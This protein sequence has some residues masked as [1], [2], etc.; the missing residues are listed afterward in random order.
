[1]IAGQKQKNWYQNGMNLTFLVTSSVIQKV[2]KL[3]F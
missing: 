3:H 1:M 2:A